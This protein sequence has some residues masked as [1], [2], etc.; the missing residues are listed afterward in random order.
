MG[1][2]GPSEQ[3]PMGGGRGRGRGRG[4]PQPAPAEDLIN[5]FVDFPEV[6]L[7]GEDK[8]QVGIVSSDT[9]R[10]MAEEAGL[11]LVCISPKADPPVCQIMDYGKLK[12]QRQKGR[13][14]QRKKSREQAVDTKELKMRPNIAEHDFQVR[15]RS[16]AKFLKSGDKVRMVCQFRGREMDFQE[17]G[18]RL[19]ERLLTELDEDDYSIDMAAKMQ[20]NQMVMILAPSLDK[21]AS[22]SRDSDDGASGGK[23]SKYKLKQ[24]AAEAAEAAAAAAEEAAEAA[25]A[26]AEEVVET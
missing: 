22:K 13:K 16:A 1:G 20:G 8:E 9:A 19:F 6:R 3:A 12:F 15:A 18:T 5:E 11:D 2:R 23:K 25:E 17:N 26:A 24:E 10:A 21:S 14:E 4:P 7:L